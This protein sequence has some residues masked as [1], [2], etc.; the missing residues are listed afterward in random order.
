MEGGILEY[1]PLDLLMDNACQKVACK[2]PAPESAFV[3]SNRKLQLPNACFDISKEGKLT[4]NE[5]C[6]ASDNL[7]DAMHKHL[8]AESDSA[9]SGRVAQAI[10][11][12]FL[13]H[14]KAL[15]ALPNAWVQFGM[16]LDHDCH[17]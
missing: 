14:F 7:V 2:P 15:K 13:G 1:I 5:Y 17:V 11:D 3:I 16:E 6:V 10:A 8:Y 4:F 9:S 12:S